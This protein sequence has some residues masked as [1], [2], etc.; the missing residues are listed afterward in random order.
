MSLFE[1]FLV[2]LVGWWMVLFMVLPFG[3]RPP[4]QPALGHAASAP[5]NPRLKRKLVV[6]TAIAL[7]LTLATYSISNA[8]AASSIY[9]AGSGD[10]GDMYHA[11]SDECASADYVPSGDVAATDTATQ[12][13]GVD[14]NQFENVPT[15]L[16]APA[17]DYSTNPALDRVGFG[18][19]NMG[20]VTTNTKT[21]ET[22][23][24]GQRIGAGASAKPAHCP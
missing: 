7:L 18:V 10:G 1:A 4:V 16:D 21:G 24:N 15:Y 13:G 19:V 11:R 5:A 14:A 9:H 6:T 3:A 12:Q 23:L 2:F 17:G 8:R 20:V 22:T